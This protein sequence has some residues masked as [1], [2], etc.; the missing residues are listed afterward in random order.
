[1]V[2]VL[3]GHDHD[4]I[5]TLVSVPP[6]CSVVATSPSFPQR[7]NVIIMTLIMR[8]GITFTVSTWNWID[9][10]FCGTRRLFRLIKLLLKPV[11]SEEIAHRNSSV[12]FS[13]LFLMR[14]RR[15][16]PTKLSLLAASSPISSE[17]AWLSNASCN[18]SSFVFFCGILGAALV[19]FNHNLNGR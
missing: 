10:K 15:P 16:Y 14:G 4:G 13:V 2:L 5:N 6:Q 19:Y 7:I 12:S 8:I 3:H 18:S 9:T 11:R 1:M 17:A